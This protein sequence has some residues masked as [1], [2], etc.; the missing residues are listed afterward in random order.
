MSVPIASRFHLVP[1]EHQRLRE[2]T[3]SI[4]VVVH[5]LML[6]VPQDL[7]AP[8][9]HGGSTPGCPPERLHSERAIL[10]THRSRL[11]AEDQLSRN[12]NFSISETVQQ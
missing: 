1:M 11:L 3:T 5:H 6:P 2:G 4:Q 7:G 9:L 10:Y 8:E 12:E